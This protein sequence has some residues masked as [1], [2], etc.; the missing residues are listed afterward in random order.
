M[1]KLALAGGLR[2]GKT[3]A[4]NYL[5]D[6]FDCSPFDF[7][8]ALKDDFHLE[9]K[10]ILREPKP[11]KGY[12]LYGQLMRYV[13]GENHWVDKCFYKVETE[14]HLEECRSIIHDDTFYFRPLITGV[15]Q[16]NEFQ[17]LREEGYF[18]IRV[19]APKELQIQRSLEAG[20]DFKEEDLLHETEVTLMNEEVH[21]DIVND[22]TIKDLHRTIDAVMLDIYTKVYKEEN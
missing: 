2:V 10:H 19:S 1:I 3:E 5:V 8:D 16:P 12:Q 17:R 18:I 9:F 6:K 15:R 11:R 22:G 14:T 20:D 21:Y 4:E 13:H 7:S